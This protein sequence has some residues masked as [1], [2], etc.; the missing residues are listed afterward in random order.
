MSTDVSEVRTASIPD[1]GDSAHLWNVGRQSFTRQY[2][3]EDNSE[4]LNFVSQVA[5]HWLFTAETRIASRETF[6]K[7]RGG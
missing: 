3:P 1:D 7:I 5:R 6:H 2:I 4:D